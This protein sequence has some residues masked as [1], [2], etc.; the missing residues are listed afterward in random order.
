MIA[1]D[2]GDTFMLEKVLNEVCAD[3][4]AIERV[5]SVNVEN[6]V[7]AECSGRVIECCVWMEK[8]DILIRDHMCDIS[9]RIRTE[10]FF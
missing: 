7:T 8:D 4:A 9:E 2:M 3:C 5:V 1:L 10:D 6:F